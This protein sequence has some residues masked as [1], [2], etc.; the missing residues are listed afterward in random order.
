MEVLLVEAFAKQ[1][2]KGNLAGVV[3]DATSLTDHDMQDIAPGQ[4]LQKQPSCSN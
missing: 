3:V 1:P 4:V 2:G